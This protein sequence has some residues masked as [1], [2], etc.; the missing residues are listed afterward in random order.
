LKARPSVEKRRKEKARQ[1][2]NLDKLHRREQRKLERAQRKVESSESGE[3]PDI[4]H[5]VP[6]PQP[7]LPEFAE[8]RPQRR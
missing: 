5:I 8:E 7:L 4:A 3:D 2:K 1:D 6:G